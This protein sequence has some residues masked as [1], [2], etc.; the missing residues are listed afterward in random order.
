MTLTAGRSRLRTYGVSRA[1][2]ICEADNEVRRIREEVQ[3]L[4]REMHAHLRYWEQKV[5]GQAALEAALQ[6]VA[7]GAGIEV[8]CR[9]PKCER[10]ICLGKS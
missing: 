2:A 6:G 3:L 10:C 9:G 4:V 7:G 5:A 8:R 1:L